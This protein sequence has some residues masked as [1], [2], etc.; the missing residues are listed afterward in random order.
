M[1]ITFQELTQVLTQVGLVSRDDLSQMVSRLSGDSTEP[2]VGLLTNELLRYGKITEFQRQL[3]LDGSPIEMG[4][5]LI[6]DR[7]GQGGMGLVYKAKHQQM[8]RIVALKVILNK[9]SLTANERFQREIKVIAAIKHPNVVTA[10]DAGDVDGVQYLV[11]EYIPGMNLSRH[12]SHNGPLQISVALRYLRQVA[13]GLKHIHDAG[14]I[15]RDIKPS[16]LLLEDSGTVK[17]TDLGLSRLIE[18]PADSEA[19]T[20]ADLTGHGQIIGTVDYMAPEQFVNSRNL[21]RRADFYSVG[22]TL[23]FLLAGKPPFAGSSAGEKVI[24]HREQRAPSL[25]QARESVSE[26]LEA[27]YQRLIAK[28]P[29]QR[30]QTADELLRALDALPRHDSA[31]TVIFTGD[32]PPGSESSTAGRAAWLD[33]HQTLLTLGTVAAAVVLAMIAIFLNSAPLPENASTSPPAGAG[34]AGAGDGAPGSPGPAKAGTLP[35]DQGAPP[36]QPQDP[37]RAAA[38]VILARGGKVDVISAGEFL[39]TV[40]VAAKLPP[41]FQIY[42]V[43]MSGS[44]VTNTDMAVLEPLDT[45]QFVDISRTKTTD[46]GLQSIARITDLQ[47]LYAGQTG[48]TD[49]GIKLLGSLS[50]LKNLDLRG[51][52]VSDAGLQELAKTHALTSLL[53]G[54]NQ[55][56]TDLGLQHLSA[57]HSLN[58]LGLRATAVTDD[59]MPSIA[60]IKNLKWLDLG[61]TGISDKGVADLEHL[62]HIEHLILSGTKVTKAGVGNLEKRCA[63]SL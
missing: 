31:T 34:A 21:D 37:H 39:P 3:L 46:V 52:R 63:V 54:E 9:S 22:C 50:N 38:E 18:W 33:R 4:N 55:Q 1:S 32:L 53:L 19:D 59:G 36:A 10:Y 57:M 5:Y 58:S 27:L 60:A 44:S 41:K 13:E 51:T 15:H 26:E 25:R 28:R 14:I 56:T 24:A 7:I 43:D 16:N 42:R 29:E 2:D 48:I 11:M 40:S 61:L 35:A 23:Y 12:V 62:N 17:I 20:M 6:L 8:G 47:T 30:F 45:I 49:A